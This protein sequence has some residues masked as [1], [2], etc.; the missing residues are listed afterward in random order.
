M[1]LGLPGGEHLTHGYH[2]AKKKN[3]QHIHLL[4]V[5]P[6]QGAPR[7]VLRTQALFFRP[8]MILCGASRHHG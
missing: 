1:G 2:T 6:V 3:L 8:V 4:R 5:S 7:E